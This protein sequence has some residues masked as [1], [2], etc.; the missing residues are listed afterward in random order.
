MAELDL[1]APYH[2]RRRSRRL[3]RRVIYRRLIGVSCLAILGGALANTGPQIVNAIQAHLAPE[4]SSAAPTTLSVRESSGDWLD[5]LKAERES[6]GD[7]GDDDHGICDAHYLADG[8][9]PSGENPDRSFAQTG[10]RATNAEGDSAGLQNVSNGDVGIDGEAGEPALGDEGVPGEENGEEDS[11]GDTQHGYIADAI[12]DE[13]PGGSGSGASGGSSSGS[14]GTGG[15]RGS[16]PNNSGTNGASDGSS[17]G[18]TGGTNGPANGAP[19][20]SEEP[21]AEDEPVISEQGTAIAALGTGTAPSGESTSG[22]NGTGNGSDEPATGARVASVASGD[23]GSGSDGSGN[24]GNENGPLVVDDLL[25]GTTP[26]DND[27]LVLADGAVNPGH[28]PGVLPIDG[29]VTLLGTLEIEVDGTSPGEFDQLLI[30]GELVLGEGALLSFIFGDDFDADDGDTLSFLYTNGGLDTLFDEEGHLD[31][32]LLG[33]SAVG[34]PDGFDIEVRLVQAER[35]LAMADDQL[36]NEP[37]GGLGFSQRLDLVIHTGG[38]NSQVAVVGPATTVAEPSIVI[39]L[40]LGLSG[41]VV[42]RRRKR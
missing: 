40:L 11:E 1:F 2:P 39:L 27:V 16:S 42:T 3:R 33:L 19:A 24:G 12:D 17:G 26:I 37:L 20:V 6:N 14:T 13:M 10:E 36:P 15:S 31:E 29:D 23:D 35:L 38:E 28:S 9:D 8:E 4:P 22:D 41:V 32:D 30:T 21:E 34:L 25:S 7:A 18:S 5:K